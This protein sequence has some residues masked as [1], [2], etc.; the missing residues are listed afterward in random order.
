VSP[1]AKSLILDLL[2]TLRG[3]AMP[4]RALVRAGALFGIAENGIRVELARLIGRGLVARDERG[5]YR[6]A[7]GAESVQSRVVSW[8]RIEERMVPWAAGWN[9]VH[10]AALPRSDRRAVRRRARAFAFLG[11]RELETGLWIRPDN[12]SGGVP[13]VRRQLDAL[14]LDRAAIVFA[15]GALDPATEAR[16]RGLWD[17]AALRAGYRATRDAILA[18][19]RRMPRLAPED[20]MVES[21]VLGGRA[22]RQLVLDPLLPEPILPTTERQALV[23]AMR[24]Y[25]KLGRACWRRFMSEHGAL[26][27]RSPVDLHTTSDSSIMNMVS[28]ATASA[29]VAGGAS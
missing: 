22:I 2:S 13:E 1:T 20:A 26:G 24:R 6:M 14:G 18:S 28:D 17:V 19:E 8:S 3:A 11:F 12:L 7:E 5:S 4:V 29:A 16:A 15:L 9:G 27:R 25:D 21:F 10:T 23:Q